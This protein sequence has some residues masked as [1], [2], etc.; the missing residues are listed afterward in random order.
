MGALVSEAMLRARKLI[1]E[2]MTP[3]RAAK[4][5]GISQSAI[6]KS[7][8]NRERLAVLRQIQDEKKPA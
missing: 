5:T 1:L 4:E 6:T 2:G 8:W 3:Y 7:K